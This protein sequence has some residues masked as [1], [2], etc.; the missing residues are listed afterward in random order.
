MLLI[1]SVNKR[2]L[3]LDISQAYS[4]A[5]YLSLPKTDSLLSCVF[6]GMCT[7]VLQLHIA[8]IINRRYLLISS[9][10]LGNALFAVT[11]PV[12]I[13]VSRPDMLHCISPL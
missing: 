9:V 6:C 3:V 13:I 5:K 11:S 2:D 4:V 10:Y 1:H 7:F 12:I 8:R